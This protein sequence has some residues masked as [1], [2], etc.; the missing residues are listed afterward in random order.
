[1]A[2]VGRKAAEATRF[3]GLKLLTDATRKIQ[4]LKTFRCFSWD[5][6]VG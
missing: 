2:F 1:M 3:D 5:R 6:V 4:R